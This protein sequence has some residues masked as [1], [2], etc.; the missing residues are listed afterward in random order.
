MTKSPY[1]QSIDACLPTGSAAWAFPETLFDAMLARCAAGVRAAARAA[2]SDGRCRCCACPSD[3]DDL[4]A[5]QRTSPAAVRQ[6]FANVVVLGIGG[7]SLGGQTL[8]RAGR[9]RLRPQAGAPTAVHR[10]SRSRHVRPSCST[11]LDPDTHR[12]HRHLQIRRHGR[13]AGA[14]V[15]WRSTGS[16]A[17]GERG[18]AARCSRIDRARRQRRCA[19]RRQHGMAILEHDPGVGGRYSVLSLVGLLPAADRRPRRR[20]DPRRR[21]GRARRDLAARRAADSAPGVGAALSVA[22]A[23]ARRASTAV[24]MPYVDRLALLRPAGIASSGPK[25]SARTARA[26][27]RSRAWARSTSTASCS[28]ISTARRTSSSR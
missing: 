11:R 2:A 19:A 25:A 16:R 3:T 9:S 12:L 4:R 23:A 28:S 22:L 8:C 7:S 1:T 27:R 13:D 18:R 5:V 21:R 10:Q 17:H 14:A 15:C 24:L 20:R 26:R 6:R